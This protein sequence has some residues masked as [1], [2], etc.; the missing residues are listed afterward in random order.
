LS[1]EPNANQSDNEEHKVESQGTTDTDIIDKDICQNEKNN[2]PIVE[3]SPLVNSAIDD[4]FPADD[5][6]GNL[7]ASPLTASQQS[8]KSEQLEEDI[9]RLKVRLFIRVL[10]LA[11]ISHS[12]IRA[13]E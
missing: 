6:V 11:W 10:S 7:G 3:V 4:M 1:I 8:Q 5:G 2:S 12:R 9:V 13:F